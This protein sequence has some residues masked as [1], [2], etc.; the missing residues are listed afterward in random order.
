MTLQEA[1]D[2][3]KQSPLVKNDI[4]KKY[5]PFEDGFIF[6]TTQEG[7]EEDDDYY[8]EGTGGY[9]I[10]RPNGDVEYTTPLDCDYDSSKIKTID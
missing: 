2:I 8:E 9:F 1:I 5:V 4:I 7:Y 3:F 10:V 6:I